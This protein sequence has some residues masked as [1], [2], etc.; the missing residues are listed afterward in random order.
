MIKNMNEKDLYYAFI[1]DSSD[2]EY[3]TSEDIKNPKLKEA[4]AYFEAKSQKNMGIGFMNFC[5]FF[6]SPEQD[7][8]IEYLA[9]E[10]FLNA[11]VKDYAK[12]HGKTEQDYTLNF[13]NYGRT[14][15]VYVLEDDQTGEKITILVKQP[16][17]PFGKAKQELENLKQ[18][19]K[20]DKQVVAPKE[21]YSDGKQ[22]L[23]TTPYINQARCIGSDG[24]WGIYI[25]E[26]FYRFEYF[27]PIQEEIVNTCMIGKLVSYYNQ[28][29]QEGI[30]ACKLGG[31]D[32][33]LKKGWEKT[34]PS[35][36][37][38]LESLYF[39]SAREKIKCSL[40]EYLQI[41]FDEFSRATINEPQE[42]ILIN[43]RGRVAMNPEHIA[44]GIDLGLKLLE[45]QSSKQPEN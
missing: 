32:F 9:F 36:E 35:I 21:Y 11:Y 12:K 4:V 26:P 2:E 40:E 42:N 34:V 25:P 41:I 19:K 3:R 30:S 23:F 27:S 33:M 38:T 5:Y 20:I 17:V 14:Q 18:L 29:T 10:E 43:H 13:I 37:N 24:K 31:G 6:C 8:M 15:V 39:I 44:K 1:I 22:E 28:E 7:A 45:E 16:I